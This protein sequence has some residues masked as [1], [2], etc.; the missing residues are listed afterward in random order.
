MELT[1]PQFD[2]LAWEILVCVGRQL[3]HLKLLLIK[4]LKVCFV[5]ETLRAH[6]SFLCRGLAFGDFTGAFC[7]ELS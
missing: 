4:P 7:R 6:N 3:H 5:K 1:R 2:Q